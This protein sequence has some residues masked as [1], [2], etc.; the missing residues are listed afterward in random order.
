MIEQL[1][2]DDLLNV[3]QR[4]VLKRV[5][6]VV[7]R[8]GQEILRR[9]MEAKLRS[10]DVYEALVDS[11]ADSE[12]ALAY[13]DQARDLAQ[14]QRTSP[15]RWLL[16]ELSLRLSRGETQD[17]QRVLRTLQERHMKEP[18]VADALLRLLVSF[19]IVVPEGP[20]AGP[21][22][23]GPP[24]VLSGQPAAAPSKLWTPGAPTAA[25]APAKPKSKLWVPGMD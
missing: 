13:L 22:A 18:G 3:F 17:A 24:P 19:G 8:G 7:R 16:H 14:R 25:D 10:E 12:E 2:D 20:G 4:A 11:A 21:P 9:N 23:G 5:D 15:A 1:S 6:V